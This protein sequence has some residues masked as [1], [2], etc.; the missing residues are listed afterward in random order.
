MPKGNEWIYF[1]Y[2]NIG[3][4]ILNMAIVYF[5]S[6][7]E[8][9][10]NWPLYRCNPMYMWLSDD[11]DEDFTGCIQTM[12]SDFMPD[13][14]E[15]LNYVV[16]QLS[17]MGLGFMDEIQSVRIMFDYIRTQITGVFNKIFGIFINL[18]IEFTKIGISLKDMMNKQ[19]GIV[20]VMLYI[21]QGTSTSV[22]SGL[23]MFEPISQITCF[24]P[25]TKIKLKNG[26]IYSMKDVPLGSILENG[27]RVQVVLS[28]EKTEPLYL[29]KKLGVNN[30][31]IY[32]S[33]SHFILYNNKYIL[34]KN[35]PLAVSQIEVQSDVYSSLITSDHTIQIGKITFWDWEDDDLYK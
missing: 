35:C 34:V 10:R 14:L 29:I 23:K 9:K 21:V 30:A 6:I 25:D 8:I 2:V 33:G 11:M 4:I 28:I 24:H 1:I 16:D 17:T 19:L 20:T 32:V 26:K 18:I 12:Q 31:D 5:G 15:P 13:L 27:A 7:A 3:F 22:S